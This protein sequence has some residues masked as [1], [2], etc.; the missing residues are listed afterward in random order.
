MRFVLH[1]L[2]CFTKKEGTEL[3]AV[4]KMKASKQVLNQQAVLVALESSLAMI[5]FNLKKEVI[6][7][8]E[9][10]ANTLG[11]ESSEMKGMVHGNFC[12]TSFKNSSD[13][14]EMWNNLEKGINFQGK[15]ERIGKN[16]ET[17]WLEATYVPVLNENGLVE[18]VLKIATNITKREEKTMEVIDQ[19]KT[20]PE[21]LVSLVI[22]NSKE[23]TEALRQLNEQTELINE[24]SRLIRKISAQTNMLALN[25]AIEAARAGE[26]GRGFNVVAGEVRK[27]SGNVS[28][29]INQVEENVKNIANEVNKVN[30][31]TER[32]QHLILETQKKFQKTIKEFEEL[33]L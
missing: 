10:F 20:M 21:E 13:Y 12:K 8:N 9:N 14:V 6:W 19:L 24:V 30:E 7:V 29:S 5:E 16:G 11:Y 17:I 32:M 31:I 25:A 4:D 3:K 1:N 2:Y 22:E 27:L 26:H 28:D 18:G 15:I 33:N 23:K